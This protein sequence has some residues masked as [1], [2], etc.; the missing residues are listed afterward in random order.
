MNVGPTLIFPSTILSS[1]EL[2]IILCRYIFIL[3]NLKH[4][5]IYPTLNLFAKCEIRFGRL[6]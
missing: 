5:Y 4:I 1:S 3:Y 2:Y 6:A